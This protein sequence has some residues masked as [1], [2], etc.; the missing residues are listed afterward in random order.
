MNVNGQAVA[1]A[2]LEAL[3]EAAQAVHDEVVTEDV[4]SLC[5][6]SLKERPHYYMCS[7]GPLAAAISEARK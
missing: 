4:C 1:Q 2:K 3:I 5:L 6:T 7:V